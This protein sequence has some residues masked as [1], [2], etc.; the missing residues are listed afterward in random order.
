MFSYY[1]SAET[2]QKATQKSQGPVYG[3]DF[4]YNG[5]LLTPDE[6]K[7][8]LKGIAKSWCFQ[9]EKGDS[10]YIHYQG[11]LSLIKKRRKNELLKLFVSPPNYL[12]PTTNPTYYR[13]DNFYV[14]KLDTRISGPWTDKDVAPVLTKQLIMFKG[15]TLRS[16]QKRIIK[17]CNIFDMRKINL[18]WDTTGCCGKSI[19]S[20]YLESEGLAEEIPPFRLMDDIFQWVC[21]RPIKPAYVV[22]M[23]RGMKKDRL[24]DFYSG[25]EVIKNGVAYDKRYKAKKIR[26]D[27]PRVFVFTNILPNLKLMSQDRWE[28]WKITSDFKIED[29]TNT[30]EF[31]E[32]DE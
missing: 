2:K 5:D 24:G 16:Y 10:G 8:F 9:L 4:R 18:I 22:D 7:G 29:I 25:I 20:E 11:R 12:A 14:Q 21:S 31:D 23:P 30:I 15:L 32:L 17:E 27:R 28:I 13:G 3:Y 26:F 6:I 19:L 1:M